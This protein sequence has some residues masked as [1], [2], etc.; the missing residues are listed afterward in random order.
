MNMLIHFSLTFGILKNHFWAEWEGGSTAAIN[1]ITLHTKT[2]SKLQAEFE[3]RYTC[4]Y[5]ATFDCDVRLLD[6]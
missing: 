6:I 3:M 5:M 4:K 2:F 1:T